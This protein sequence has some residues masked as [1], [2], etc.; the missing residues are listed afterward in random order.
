MSFRG[1]LDGLA[2]DSLLKEVHEP[3]SPYLEAAERSIGAGPVLFENVL[4]QR[5]VMNILG[6]RALLARALSIP[7]R[8]M[9]RHLSGI[10][11]SG[12]VDYVDSSPFQEVVS[13][14]GPDKAAHSHLLPGRRRTL[15]HLG[16]GG[17]PVC[18]ERSTPAFT[19]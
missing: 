1:F 16:S 5:C 17:D 19:G 3:V 14:P 9:V 2:A 15:H 11:C 8:D 7:A 4:G 13:E 12:Q 18:R 6:T 10:D